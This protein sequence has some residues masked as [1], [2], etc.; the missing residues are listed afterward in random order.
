VARKTGAGG[1]IAAMTFA[2]VILAIEEWWGD[3]STFGYAVSSAFEF[4]IWITSGV[5]GL[6]LGVLLF[7][8]YR[9]EDEQDYTSFRRDL[10]WIMTVAL[11]LF[12]YVFFA[13]VSAH[14]EVSGLKAFIEEF[15]FNDVLKACEAATDDEG[16]GFRF[17]QAK[18][19]K[20]R[21]VVSTGRF[22]EPDV[23]YVLLA[24]EAICSYDPFSKSAK[25]RSVSHNVD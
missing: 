24:D 4:W 10:I 6:H 17:R 23:S 8:Y 11:G 7:Q 1:V 13:S 20:V 12:V 5:F 9:N 2:S 3:K 16:K 25:L 14:R 21:G 15:L 19:K 18:F 22:G